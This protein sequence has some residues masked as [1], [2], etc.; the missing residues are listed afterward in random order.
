MLL[1]AFPGNEPIS[2]KDLKKKLGKGFQRRDL[3]QVLCSLEY[4]G[5][6]QRVGTTG[7]LGRYALWQKK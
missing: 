3:G 4:K 7:R 6:V 5:K 2:V 1:E